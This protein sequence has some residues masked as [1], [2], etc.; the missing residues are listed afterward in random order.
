MASVYLRSLCTVEF[1]YVLSCHSSR[2]KVE[3]MW[4]T[5]QL[6]HDD[7]LVDLGCLR[8][9]PGWNWEELYIYTYLL[10]GKQQSH[11]YLFNKSDT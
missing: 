9:D 4:E 6:M 1:P 3:D 11:N 8:E 2:D 5:D 10:M 7:A